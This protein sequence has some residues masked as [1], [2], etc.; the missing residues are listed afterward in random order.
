MKSLS[1]AMAP[2]LRPLASML[3]A[4][5]AMVAS[6][7]Q[8]LG[9]GKAE[10]ARAATPALVGFSFS[11]RTAVWL[12]EDPAPAL[13][14]LLDELTPDLVR[15][16]VYWDS[17]ELRPGVFDFSETD[18][19]LSI[20]AAYNRSHA[21]RPVRVIL[22]AGLRNMGYPELYVPA[23]VPLAERDPASRMDVDPRYQGYLAATVVHYR[24]SP[25]LY[26]WQIENEPLDNVPTTAGTQV[27][28]DGDHLQ[29]ELEKVRA[30]DGRHPIVMTTYNSATLSLDMAALSPGGSHPSSGPQ[31][32][33]HPLGALQLGDALGLDVYV[34]T[35]DTSLTDASAHKRID[36]K[37]RALVY[38]AGQAEALSKPLWITEMQGAPWPGQDDFKPADLL[39]SANAYRHHGA[40]VILLWGVESWLGSSTWM[41]AGRQ[42]RAVLGG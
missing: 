42:A 10:I 13:Q 27:D 11:P 37:S 23:W 15:L 17:V 20:V 32:A 39:Y 9:V 30:M 33:G 41:Q 40:T 16:P 29:D 28:I 19:M 22:V 2:G 6:S 4:V 7:T 34:V 1:G 36:W 21:G 14:T 26:S 35:G 25:L 31:P 12:G 38:W 24:R 5:G 8:P 18:R 3:L